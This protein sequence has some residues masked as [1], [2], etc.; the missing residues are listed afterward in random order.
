MGNQI[1]KTNHNKDKTKWEILKQV[2]SL[3]QT[4]SPS[5]RSVVRITSHTTCQWQ[6]RRNFKIIEIRYYF[7]RSCREK[8]DKT[9]IKTS[10]RL[11]SKYLGISA[12]SL[13]EPCTDL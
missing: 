4:R 11:T 2:A 8:Q 13:R 3:K 12:M 6:P 9:K 7:T 10:R 1:N 5:L